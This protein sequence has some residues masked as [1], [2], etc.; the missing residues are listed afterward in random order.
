MST[1][2]VANRNNFIRWNKITGVYPEASLPSVGVPGAVE[3]SNS[4]DV[5]LSEFV[6]STD[7]VGELSVGGVFFKP[8]GL[9]M[10][11]IGSFNDVLTEYDLSTAWDITT[12]SDLQTENIVDDTAM[13]DIFFRSDGAKMYLIGTGSD[14]VYEYDLSTAW[15]ISTISLNQS[16]SVTTDDNNPT[17]LFFRPDGTQMF[18]CGKENQSVY[19]YSLSS[20][21]DISTSML[22]NSSSV[23]TEDSNPESISFSSDGL[24]LI[25]SGTENSSVYTFGLSEAWNVGNVTFH[26]SFDTSTQDNEPRGIYFRDGFNYYVAGNQNDDVY[27]YEIPEKFNAT[28]TGNETQYD[29][30]QNYAVT[31]FAKETLSFYANLDTL[32][33]SANFA[34]WRLDIVNSDFITQAYGVATL[35]QDIISGSDYRFYLDQWEILDYLNKGCYRFVIIDTTD[36]T[37]K[38]ISNVWDYSSTISYFTKRIRY[39]NPE[40]ILNF[41]YETLTTYKNEFR[42]NMVQRQPSYSTARTGYTLIDGSFNPVRTTT[43]MEFDFITE[44]YNDLDHEAWNAATIHELEIYNEKTGQ[45]EVFK[46]SEDAAYEVDW[47]DNYPFADG[48]IKLEQ[49]NTYN[50]SKNV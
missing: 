14:A 19:G 11:T 26:K 17:G 2:A 33:D 43:G 47:Q 9:K 16:F 24:T 45:W 3:D 12:A 23:L 37:V 35:T 38:Y 41:D 42:V 40:D 10:Y 1:S 5:S 36:N 4:F 28:P 50:S 30:I 20:A 7:I 22:D 32:E 18:I 25:M 21:W 15:D 39:R 8:D 27:Q 6:G 29:D 48:T 34:S 31:L 49:E 46:R 44:N 13:T